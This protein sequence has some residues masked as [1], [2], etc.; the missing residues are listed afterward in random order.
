MQI[1]LETERLVLRRFTEDDV[2]N[3]VELDSD[4]EVMHYITG[5]CATPREETEREELP[6]FLECYERYD[7]YGFLAASTGS[8]RTRSKA[9][10]RAT[11][12]TRWRDPI[13]SEDGELVRHRFPKAP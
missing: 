11:W 9:R 1:F 4:P 7:G 13:G 8:G 5:G 12:S 6:H 10:K 2:D 3:L